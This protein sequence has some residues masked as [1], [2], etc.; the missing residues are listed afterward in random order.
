MSRERAVRLHI[1][2]PRTLEASFCA[3]Q[4]QVGEQLAQ[5]LRILEEQRVRA[6]VQCNMHI[7]SL[8]RERDELRAD[9]RESSSFRSSRRVA[10][11]PSLGIFCNEPDP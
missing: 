7:R 10:H 9:H 3:R 2:L 5:R 6:E 1:R 4:Y 8:R 11:C